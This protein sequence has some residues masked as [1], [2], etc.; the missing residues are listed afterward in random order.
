MYKKWTEE[1][2]ALVTE[3]YC[4][5]HT[6]TETGEKFGR[7]KYSIE[8]FVKDN[9]LSN[10]RAF[11]DPVHRNISGLQAANEARH[12]A[13]LK[14]KTE[15][16]KRRMLD[17]Q[18]KELEKQK[19]IKQ[20]EEQRKQKA[21]ERERAK[22]EK[23]DALFHLLNDKNHVC[24]VCGKNFSVSEFMENKGRKLIPTNPKYCS[25]ECENKHNNRRSKECKRRRGVRDTHRHRAKKYGCDYDPTVTLKK[26]IARDGL[27]C[28]ICG[29]M[30]DPNDHSWSRYSGPTSPSIDHIIAMARGGGH[31]WENVQVAHIICNSEKGDSYEAS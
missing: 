27:R 7:S 21:F 23:A 26:L 16:A 12:L 22:A 24:S 1:E 2:K 4:S 29:K 5:G 13:S 8:C 3:Y 20:N 11:R 10:G 14:R 28:A 9:H 18:E 30:C 15:E 17:K 6:A 25:K 19:I 31:V